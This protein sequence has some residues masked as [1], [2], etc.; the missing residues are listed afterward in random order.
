MHPLNPT[1]CLVS[2]VEQE[3]VRCVCY[4]TF[5]D[6][7]VLVVRL[8]FTP[9][10]HCVVHVCMSVRVK[11]SMSPQVL[12]DFV[13][14]TRTRLAHAIFKTVGASAN[15]MGSAPTASTVSSSSSS[16]TSAA[17]LE[18]S[19]TAMDTSSGPTPSS[20]SLLDHFV[21]PFIS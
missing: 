7:Q 5:N 4:H 9:V 14:G 12:L 15:T 11:H 21:N 18:S 8:F 16:A 2:L 13:S 20:G 10:P 6:L 1:I 19:S 17:F 3:P